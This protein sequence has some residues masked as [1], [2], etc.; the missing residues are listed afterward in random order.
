MRERGP[1]ESHFLSHKWSFRYFLTCICSFIS[2]L[3]YK[4]NYVWLCVSG[5][6]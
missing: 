2:I 4:K 1:D 6:L 3:F 5:S